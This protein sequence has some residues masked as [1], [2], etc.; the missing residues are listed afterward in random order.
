[1][2]PFS[3]PLHLS[4]VLL[5]VLSKVLLQVLAQV[6]PVLSVLLS[7]VPSVLWPSLLD[8]LEQLGYLLWE[9]LR[10]LSDSRLLS[11]ASSEPPE[12]RKRQKTKTKKGVLACPSQLAQLLYH[13]RSDDTTDDLIGWIAEMCGRFDWLDC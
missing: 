12:N 11:V 13:K 4:Q 2:Q 7:H 8:L 10:F 6:P 9:A 1:L 3:L 5:Q